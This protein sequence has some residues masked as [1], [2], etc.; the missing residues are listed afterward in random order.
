MSYSLAS[1]SH[2]ASLG[3]ASG[4][5]T[6]SV[7]APAMHLEHPS[8]VTVRPCTAVVGF[9]QFQIKKRSEVVQFSQSNLQAGSQWHV[10]ELPG[11]RMAALRTIP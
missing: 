9:I 7:F 8:S 1:L 5:H 10:I 4:Y 3:Q 6:T 11:L 2:L